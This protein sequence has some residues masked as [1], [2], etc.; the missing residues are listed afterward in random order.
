M[1]P[2]SDDL[3]Q[4]LRRNL[5]LRRKLG[6]EAAKGKTALSGKQGNGIAYRFGP[7]LLWACLIVAAILAVVLLVAR[8]G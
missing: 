6:A 5:K 3:E 7:V 4:E 2:D 1:T 8:Q